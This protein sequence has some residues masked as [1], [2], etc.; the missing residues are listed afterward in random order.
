MSGRF[1]PHLQPPHRRCCA[2]RAAQCAFHISGR[3]GC[4]S[5]CPFHHQT[6]A[7]RLATVTQHDL[8]TELECRH[9]WLDTFPLGI[10]ATFST[11]AITRGRFAAFS[12]HNRLDDDNSGCGRCFPRVVTYTRTTAFLFAPT[13]A[14]SP[15]SL[16][17]TRRLALAD[18]YS[19]PRTA[20]ADSSTCCDSAAP[21]LSMPPSL[22]PGAPSS[23]HHRSSHLAEPFLVPASARTEYD[24]EATTAARQPLNSGSRSRESARHGTHS[25]RPRIHESRSAEA[26]FSCLSGSNRTEMYTHASVTHMGACGAGEASLPSCSSLCR[27]VAVTTW[28]SHQHKGAS[29][30][31]AAAR[32]GAPPMNVMGR[33]TPVASSSLRMRGGDAHNR[34]S[35]VASDCTSAVPSS[36]APAS[37]A[38]LLN[39]QRFGC[40]RVDCPSTT[41]EELQQQRQPV[42]QRGQCCAL[43][44][45]AEHEAIS[46]G[47]RRC[48]RPRSSQHMEREYVFQAVIRRDEAN[49]LAVLRRKEPAFVVPSTKAHAEAAILVEPCHRLSAAVRRETSPLRHA[50]IASSQ[51]RERTLPCDV[52]LPSTNTVVM[53]AVSPRSGF[54]K[55]ESVDHLLASLQVTPYGLLGCVSTDPVHAGITGVVAERVQGT[56]IA[57]DEGRSSASVVSSL[58]HNLSQTSPLGLAGAVPSL[59]SRQ[60]SPSSVCARLTYSSAQD[61]GCFD[62]FSPCFCAAEVQQQQLF[63]AAQRCHLIQREEAAARE[64]LLLDASVQRHHIVCEER[65][66]Y[67]WV[68]SHQ[69]HHRL[70]VTSAHGAVCAGASD[71]DLVHARSTERSP[72]PPPDGVFHLVATPPFGKELRRIPSSSPRSLLC[73]GTFVET[74]APHEDNREKRPRGSALPA[75][76]HRLYDNCSEGSAPYD[77][78]A[79]VGFEEVPWYAAEKSNSWGS[80]EAFDYTTEEAQAKKDLTDYRC[81]E[82]VPRQPRSCMRPVDVKQKTTVPPWALP[83]SPSGEV[84]AGELIACIRELHYEEEDQRF[85]LSGEC[86]PPDV[87]QRWADRYFEDS[88]AS[89]ALRPSC[90][91]HSLPL[92]A[93]LSSETTERCCSRSDSPLI[94]PPTHDDAACVAPVPS[95]SALAGI[96]AAGSHDSRGAFLP[97]TVEGESKP[98]KE[99][100]LSREG[101]SASWHRLCSEHGGVWAMENFLSTDDTY[102]SNHAEGCARSGGSPLPSSPEQSEFN[103]TGRCAP[104]PRIFGTGLRAAPQ[105]AFL[106][107]S[108]AAPSAS[109][110]WTPQIGGAA[111][112][113]KSGC[114][115]QLPKPVAADSSLRYMIT[116]PTEKTYL[117]PL[118][119]E[120][121][122]WQ[123]LMDAFIDGFL[124]IMERE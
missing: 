96:S 53:T 88:R 98:A 74:N 31:V 109:S 35:D 100:L 8:L 60:A 78:H 122:A 101:T 10:M 56:D 19:S 62:R 107:T 21:S 65:A 76:L 15:S 117:A 123:A 59:P 58:S 30:A 97:A 79:P 82:A 85:L 70:L 25:H 92:G 17:P 80:D 42:R 120:K 64:W 48:V 104:D 34:V 77:Q 32:V 36:R 89:F 29:G 61:D 39:T 55:K 83:P 44:D 9:S 27:S 73:A 67:R 45:R 94:A 16:L 22:P 95:D 71:N 110:P 2:H 33:G 91:R 102:A 113:A 46:M 118:G 105:S 87:F 121:E 49:A 69:D 111:T 37:C 28:E 66:A 12:H 116:C 54:P 57:H 40:Q 84:L 99:E 51:V 6:Q 103:A 13:A 119:S 52:P 63:L 38:S 72:S 93:A 124:Q 114:S 108:H 68:K 18:Q 81:D 47:T 75:S 5:H 41:A 26:S 50:L 3:R 7:D 11:A 90:D 14:T 106:L 23:A 4:C 43:R 24:L 112:D 20:P 86:P 1:P 115:R